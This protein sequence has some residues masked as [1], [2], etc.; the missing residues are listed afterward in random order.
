MRRD[1]DFRVEHSSAEKLDRR[2]C[3]DGVRTLRS[4][5]VMDYKLTDEGITMS[6]GCEERPRFGIEEVMY[7]PE[8]VVTLSRLGN[9]Q[10]LNDVNN[11]EFFNEAVKLIH[12]NRCKTAL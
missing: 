2:L 12:R 7:S 4:N 8:E 6:S 1:Q 3:G 11:L 10:L 9:V 5:E